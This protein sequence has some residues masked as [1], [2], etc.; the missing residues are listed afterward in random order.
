MA[1]LGFRSCLMCGVSWLAPL[2]DADYLSKMINE[3]E[4]M[5]NPWSVP[6][7]LPLQS[8]LTEKKP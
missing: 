6:S 2:L 4:D 7:V 8:I 3:Q 5:F 1:E